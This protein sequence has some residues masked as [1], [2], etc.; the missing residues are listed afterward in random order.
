[1]IYQFIVETLLVNLLALIISLAVIW[2]LQPFFNQLTGLDLSLRVLLSGSVFGIP[3]SLVFVVAF[4]LSLIL[5]SIYPAT[6]LAG[7]QAKEVINGKYRLRGKVAWLR[8]GLVIFQFVTAIAL[9]NGALAISDQVDYLL[10]KDL[11]L[12]IE[13]TMIVYGTAMTNWDSTFIPKVDQFRN[14]AQRLK[15]VSLVSMSNRVAGDRMGR[16]F[17]V[18]NKSLENVENLT[19]NSMSVDFNFEK[20]YGLKILEG[21]GLE[22]TDYNFDPDFINNL[23]INKTAV[24]YLGFNSVTAV[25]GA[26]LFFGNRDWNIVGV[27]DDF[28]QLTLR[29]K[30]ELIVLMPYL[31]TYN[32]YSIKLDS[33]PNE[34]L[35]AGIQEVYEETFPGNYFDYYFLED[36]YQCYY[37]PEMRLS[38]ISKVFTALS[39][40]MVILGLYGLITMTLEKKIKEIGIRKVLGA[41][42]AQLLFHLTKDFASLMLIALAIGVPLSLYLIGLW[43]DDIAY[44]TELG[45]DSIIIACLTI[46]VFTSIPILLQTNRV[47]RNNPVEELRDD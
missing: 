18:K 31:S 45:V 2:L 28:H 32:R 24:K 16:L 30:I 4:V 23:I 47:V 14:E 20:L 27:V 11:G 29:E 46:L 37:K 25:I 8:K 10:N 21:R 34:A 44:T 35:I 43:K 40:I 12:D 38:Y 13:N 5:I 15:G 26:R 22:S 3:F 42:V 7:F 6:L 19:L 41:K 17:R 36:D 39:I 33:E 1:M 9:I